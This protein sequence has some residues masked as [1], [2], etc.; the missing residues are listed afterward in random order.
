MTENKIIDGKEISAQIREKVKEFGETLK[1]ES[2][3][4]PG[5]AVV[6]VGENPASKVYVKNKIEK[7]KE[8]GFTSIEHRL[9]D[10]VSEEELLNVVKN[11]NEDDKVQGILVQLPLPKHINADKVLD[12][13]KPV[14]DVDGFHAENV[15]KL[16]SG[17]DS[18]VPC[19]PLGCSIMLKKLNPDLSGK[20]AIIIGRSNIVG[21]PMA[22]LLLG[23]NATVTIAH[24]RT[25][26]VEEL[27]KP[28]DI[29]VAA[30]GIPEMVKGSWIKKGAVVI[31]V[32]INRIE[33]DG[34]KV[35][36]GDVDYEECLENSSKITPVPGGVGPMTIACLLLNTLFTSY[37]QFG[38]KPL[39][40]GTIL[41]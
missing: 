29:V 4:T 15:G 20:K 41:E 8:V 33:R 32:G 14:K 7:T 30:V 6:L 16:W 9:N 26:N 27:V 36:V 10:G 35:L 1:K 11:L 39:D 13:I 2:G 40:L 38:I 37:E 17:L 19:T 22:A 18:L 24:S 23:M 25:K 5:L 21:K 34:K 3:R 12:T 31:D 28:A